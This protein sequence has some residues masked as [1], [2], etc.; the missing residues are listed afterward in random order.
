MVAHGDFQ[1]TIRGAMSA[2]LTSTLSN[3]SRAQSFG[4]GVSCLWLSTNRKPSSGFSV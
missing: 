4:V 2:W 1:A 3:P